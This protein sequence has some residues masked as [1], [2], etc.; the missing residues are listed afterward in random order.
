MFTKT[1]KAIRRIITRFFRV[2]LVD[3]CCTSSVADRS[4]TLSRE[5]LQ[6]AHTLKVAFRARWPWLCWRYF[7][8]ITYKLVD[9]D[10]EKPLTPSTMCVTD[11]A[12]SHTSLF[13]IEFPI[14]AVACNREFHL[15]IYRL[16]DGRRLGE[17]TFQKLRVVQLIDEIRNRELTLYVNQA[18]ERLQCDRLHDQVEG[19][20]LSFSINL[21]DAEHRQLLNEMRMVIKVLLCPAGST[22]RS[23]ASWSKQL[24]FTGPR[25]HWDESL[26]PATAFFREAWSEYAFRVFLGNSLIA[27][28]AIQVMPLKAYRESVRDKMRE[29]AIVKEVRFFALDHRE[30]H[31]PLEVV[32]EDFG[33]LDVNLVLD[34]PSVDPLINREELPLSIAVH[35]SRSGLPV[36][37]LTHN[38]TTRAGTS[39]IEQLSVRIT[40]ELFQSGTG[41]YQI[42]LLLDSRVLAQHAFTH[43]T[44]LQIRKEKAQ[45]IYNSLS[46]SAAQLL[47]VREGRR[48]IV[49]DVVFETDELVV[50]TFKIEGKGFDDDVSTL[51]WRMRVVLIRKDS[52]QAHEKLVLLRT[53]TGNNFYTAPEI[54]LND[55]TWSLIPG[56]YTLRLEKKDQC[57]KEFE[58]RVLALPEII[59]YTEQLVLQNLRADEQ[60]LSIRCGTFEY[61]SEHV[62]DTSDFIIPTLTLRTTGFNSHLPQVKTRLEIYLARPKYQRTRLAELHIDLRREPVILSNIAIKVRGT[63]WATKPGKFKLIFSAA[64]REITSFTVILVS[65]KE[66]LG[67][68][69]VADVSVNAETKTGRTIEKPTTVTLTEHCAITP[70]VE[71]NVGI[72]APNV[73]F[74]CSVLLMENTRVLMQA[75][76]DLRLNETRKQIHCGR[77]HL[78]RLRGSGK[79]NER[80]LVVAVFFGEEKKGQQHFTLISLQMIAN[81]EGQ[82]TVAPERMEIDDSEYEEI[83]Q[84]L[85]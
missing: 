15:R 40:P 1:V 67:S 30:E 44:R 6:G 20:E 10:G 66:L 76:F 29:N 69:K 24:E 2:E 55:K 83:L 85:K 77:I 56:R 65:Q 19:L 14:T 46:L 51:K 28:K 34:V 62:P 64:G 11:T 36:G 13:T 53:G 9:G 50:P 49:D 52:G 70:S 57:L 59:P 26:G 78:D 71:I 37:G 27:S 81:F 47:V 39:C 42:S 22:D 35:C 16:A 75:D 45:A 3:F 4:F 17:A 32:A 8:P 74:A 72:I 25:Y 31:V 84:R 58:F 21:P 43:Q 60:K 41:Q 63:N 61:Q 68:V 48:E 33:S 79:K 82:L 80:Q 12:G 38:I 23:L 54:L 18:N 73:V 7:Q 5:Y